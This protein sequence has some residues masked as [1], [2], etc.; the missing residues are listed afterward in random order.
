MPKKSRR[1]N[2]FNLATA[3]DIM[4]SGYERVIGPDFIISRRVRYHSEIGYSTSKVLTIPEQKFIDTLLNIKAKNPLN[5]IA[6]LEKLAQE[7]KKCRERL[8]D[9]QSNLFQYVLEQDLPAAKELGIFDSYFSEIRIR[10]DAEM[11]VFY[12]YIALYRL[13]EQKRAVS[14]WRSDYPNLMNETNEEIAKTYELAQFS[15]LRLDENLEHGAIKVTDVIRKTE[16][17][18]MDKALNESKLEGCFFI[19]ST[20]N[21]DKYIMTSGG[22]IPVDPAS[23]IGKFALTLVRKQMKKLR[24]KK[25]VL[26]EEISEC[27]RE[28]YGFCLS[29]GLLKNMTVK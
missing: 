11:N 26:D 25:E 14:K 2:L 21:R 10:N 17:I 3:L 28:I 16:S 12:D 13:I 23:K 4:L 9:Y 6:N 15:I 27:V 19:C 24:A 8:G 29:A 7:Y 20:L 1:N 18:L 5:F 22:G